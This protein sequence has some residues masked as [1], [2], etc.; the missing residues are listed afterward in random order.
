MCIR[1]RAQTVSPEVAAKI[2]M[3]FNSQPVKNQ[4]L[5]SIDDFV[6]DRDVALL[7]L[8]FQGMGWKLKRIDLRP[9]LALSGPSGSA[10]PLFFPMVDTYLE[11]GNA[12][13]QKGDWDGAIADFTQ[14]LSIDPQ[15]SAAFSARGAARQSKGDLDGAIKDY[16]QALA[17]DPQMAAAYELSLIHI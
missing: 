9:D 17:I 15:S 3:A 13:S 12:L 7:H 1:D 8:Q 16:T 10:S 11:Q 5:A 4:G 2:L 6:L 14:I